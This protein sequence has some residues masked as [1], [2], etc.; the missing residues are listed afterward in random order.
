MDEQSGESKEEEVMGEGM[1]VNSEY[2]KIYV[3]PFDESA[4][5]QMEVVHMPLERCF[6]LQRVLFNQSNLYVC[7]ECLNH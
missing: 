2:F 4:S 3:L 7:C 5:S 6:V 1:L